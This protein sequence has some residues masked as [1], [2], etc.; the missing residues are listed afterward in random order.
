MKGMMNME[1]LKIIVSA[2]LYLG[3][4]AFIYGIYIL[5]T[6]KIPYAKKIS[7]DEANIK[8]FC[9]REGLIFMGWGCLSLL[10]TIYI[11]LTNHVPENYLIVLSF[12]GMFILLLLRIKNNK[13]Y[14][15]D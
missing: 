7:I 8:D 5:C 3:D 12:L 15:K 14:M 6:H 1:Q 4:F 9:L 11:A 13:H 2:A 10:I